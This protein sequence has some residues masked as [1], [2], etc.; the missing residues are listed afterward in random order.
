[1]MI[2]DQDLRSRLQL[3][4]DSL[5]EFKQIEFSGHK[6]KSPRKE[7][8]ADEIGAFAN[9]DGG[10][11]LCGITDEGT[12]QDMSKE[13]MAALGKMLS[14]IC[15]DILEP[16]LRISVH[17]R[18]LDQKTLI[19]VEVPRGYSVHARA[20]K[21]FI[22]VGSMKTRMQRDEILRI[23]QN[24]T[25]SRYIWTDKQTVPETGFE[26]LS[27]RLWELLLSTAGAIDPQKGL[28][29]LHLLAENEEGI[30][31]ATLAGILLCTPRP[32]T[33]LPYAA[34]IATHYRGLDRASGQLDAQEINGPLP[35]QIADAV[36]FVVR[37]MRVSAHK[38]PDRENLPQYSMKA[39]FEAV[40]NAV[41]HRDYSI[42]SRKIRLSMFNDRVE[43]ESPGMLP[44]G[45]T[46]DSMEA[47]QS[48]RNEVISS[49]FGH[50]PITDIAGS[51]HRRYLM[52]RRGDGVSIIRTETRNTAGLLPEYELIENSCLVLRIPAAKL[53]LIPADATVTVH[54]KGEPLAGIEVLALFPNKTSVKATT[55]ESGNAALNL[56]T[57]NLPMRI[58]VAGTQH[59]AGLEHNWI[60]E[61]GGLMVDLEP[62]NSGGS[63][64]F[65]RGSGYLPGLHGRLNPR[66]DTSDRT[67]IYADNI[68]IDDGRQQPVPFRLGK[69]LRLTDAYGNELSLTIVDIVSQCCLVEYRPYNG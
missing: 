56:Y 30:V 18:K 7:D 17:N 40:V 34:I 67:Y 10:I 12:I 52:E 38:N 32:Q 11:L 68:A 59:A 14:E 53:E 44:N 58:Y 47:S 2:Q 5:W 1:M 3:G 15:T 57:T 61:S 6:P 35:Q 49:V 13:Q 28:K 8:L 39:V 21:A 69:P 29:N 50:F 54:S 62:L 63:V 43:I 22:R 65:T 37:N 31:Q 4:E 16:P 55:D 46:I 26:T 51:N 60:P 64:I 25:K 42:S 36:Q 41:A 9:A 27:E 20:G 45:M 33:W 23:T 48:T 24:R 66:H 19:V